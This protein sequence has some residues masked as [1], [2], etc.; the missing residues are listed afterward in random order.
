[1]RTGRR[2]FGVYN[3]PRLYLEQGQGKKSFLEHGST[4]MYTGELINIK[5]EL[6]EIEDGHWITKTVTGLKSEMPSPHSP[7]N[8]ADAEY[9][10]G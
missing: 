8:P 4:K 5:L 2:C 7:V 9:P 10:F 6:Q 1:M 3:I